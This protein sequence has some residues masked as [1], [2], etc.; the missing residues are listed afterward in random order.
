[1]AVTMGDPAALLAYIDGSVSMR[2]L[3]IPPSFIP[4]LMAVAKKRHTDCCSGH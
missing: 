4:L 3:L 2:P 1:M